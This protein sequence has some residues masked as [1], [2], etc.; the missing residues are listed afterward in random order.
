[1]KLDF[2][3]DKLKQ[4]ETPYYFYDTNLLK[5]T[6]KAISDEIDKKKNYSVHY[7][8]KANANPVLLNIIS[9]AGFGADCV[10]GGEIKQALSCGFPAS[11]IVFAGIGKADWEINLALKNNISC[12]NVESLGELDVLNELATKQEKIANIALR[13]N[14]DVDIHTN[15][16][17]TTGKAENKFGIA[18]PELSKAIEMSVAKNNVKLIGIHF[19]VGSQITDMKDFVNLC[20]RINELQEKLQKHG[21]E[22]ENVNVGGGLGIDYRHPNRSPFADFEAYFATF[23]QNLHLLPGQSLHFELGRSIIGQCGSLISRVLY[24]KQ[25]VQ[26]KFCVLD[27]GM[28]EILRP[29]LYKAYHKIENLSSNQPEERYDI[30]GPVCESTDV[31]AENRSVNACFRGDIVAI[32]SAGAYGESMSSQYNFRPLPKSFTEEDFK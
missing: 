8:I 16:N 5:R 18:L 3:I 4:K 6:L 7:A 19:H 1:M 11:K 28:T 17:I 15:P 12:F 32:R 26:K 9:K 10:S 20:N 13:I 25:G 21:I 2:P 27:A 24:V 22:I 31:L 23:E 29:A 14:P 30:V